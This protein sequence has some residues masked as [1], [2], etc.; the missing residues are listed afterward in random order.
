MR[1]ALLTETYFPHINGVTTHVKT[2][3]EGLT[4]LG[5][6][7]L[8]V[9]ASPNI[10]K[11]FVEDGV[12]YCPGRK[13][14]RVYGYGLASPFSIKRMKILKEFNPDIIHV[15]NEF[16]IGLFG[17]I[18]AKRLKSTL[19]YTLHTDYDSYMYYVIPKVLARTAGK[20]MRK[21]IN[22]YAKQSDGIIGPSSKCFDYIKKASNKKK[23]KILSNSIELSQFSA[24]NVSAQQKKDLL[25]KLGL[26]ENAF[27][28]CFVGRMGNEKAI[29]VTLD[30]LAKTLQKGDNIFY[31][32]AGDGPTIEEFKAQANRLNISDRVRFTGRVEHDDIPVYYAISKVFLTSSLTEMN[33]I[34]MLEAMAMGLPVLQRVDEV[35]KDQI[36]EGINGYLFNDEKEMYM[37]LKDL[38]RMSQK[39]FEK[40]QNLTSETVSQKDELDLAKRAVEVYEI[41]IQSGL[42]QIDI[43][44]NKPANV[45]RRRV[46]DKVKDVK[47]KI[48][49]FVNQDI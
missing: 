18:A 45:L 5:H 30:F 46:F 41:A 44:N 8:V 7:V 9:T 23:I 1:V 15:H 19:I 16:G 26:P 39:D 36:E 21:Y 34:S 31:L 10:S 3:R 38:S 2:L 25:D 13:L 27:I 28:A 24:E 14:K 33:S 43:R 6:E 35:N 11:H 47:D 37:H 17:I 12:L 29:D 42:D 32:A 4:A 48:S 49:D 22:I 40:I 20:I